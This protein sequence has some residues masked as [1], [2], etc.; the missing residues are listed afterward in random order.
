MVSWFARLVRPLAGVCLVIALLGAGAAAASAQSTIDPDL[1]SDGDGT[2]NNMDFDDDND[3]YADDA[4]CAPFD[5]LRWV[6]CDAAAS[7]NEPDNDGDGIP[8]RADPEDHNDGSV[9]DQ[10]PHPL[11]PD[12]GP[13]PGGTDPDPDNDG[14]GIADRVDPDDDND[15]VMD[16]QDSHPFDP[17]RGEKPPPSIVYSQTY[18]VGDGIANSHDPDDDNDGVVDEVDCAPFDPSVS[19][20]PDPAPGTDTPDGS[21]GDFVTVGN[22]GSRG[23]SGGGPIV[24]SLPSTGVGATSP[25]APLTAAMGIALALLALA[26]LR[27]WLHPVRVPERRR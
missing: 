6:D 8:D 13:A 17:D 14:D 26:G 19:A 7:S 11:T 12:V 24:T 23:V 10:L 2:M 1:D 5:N 20:C 15:G 18:C 25:L 16:E 27:G 4:D 3:G 22:S 9:D 21:T